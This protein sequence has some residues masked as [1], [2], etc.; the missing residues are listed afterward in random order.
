MFR[1][2]AVEVI[3]EALPSVQEKEEETFSSSSSSRMGRPRRA[4]KLQWSPNAHAARDP[5][6]GYGG[7]LCFSFRTHQGGGATTI[8]STS[9]RNR[10]SHRLQ[11]QLAIANSR[12]SNETRSPRSPSRS[13]VRAICGGAPTACTT[14]A[15]E[16]APPASAPAAKAAS[17]PGASS[18]TNRGITPTTSSNGFISSF[19]SRGAAAPASTRA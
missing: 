2:T 7:S 13:S 18:T 16:A 19:N 4:S 5:R 11:L 3:D 10:F 14:P 6:S 9:R 15:E 1:Q 8:S 12:F 17:F